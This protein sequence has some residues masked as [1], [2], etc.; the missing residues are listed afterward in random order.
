M[1]T[2]P[3]GEEPGFIVWLNDNTDGFFMFADRWN[4]YQ[5]R[6]FFWEAANAKPRLVNLPRKDRPALYAVSEDPYW[7]VPGRDVLW[8]QRY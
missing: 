5:D 2:F 6:L 1:L 4:C 8:V 3:N 7:D